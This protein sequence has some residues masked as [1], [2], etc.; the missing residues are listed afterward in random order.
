[1]DW[2]H[3]STE[4]AQIEVSTSDNLEFRLSFE[5]FTVKTVQTFFCYRAQPWSYKA[6]TVDAGALALQDKH[7][8]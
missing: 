5:Q 4:N 1:M 3:P 8:H 2:R 6:E 7:H